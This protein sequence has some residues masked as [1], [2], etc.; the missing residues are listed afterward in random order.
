MLQCP[1]AV[2]QWR[3][4]LRSAMVELTEPLHDELAAGVEVVRRLLEGE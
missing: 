1:H 4:G 2:L 3:R